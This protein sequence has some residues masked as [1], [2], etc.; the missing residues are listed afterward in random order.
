[1]ASQRIVSVP[2]QAQS[3]KH[4]EHDLKHQ[5]HALGMRLREWQN[6]RLHEFL[7]DAS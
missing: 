5:T 3:Q 2:Q 4:P 6:T 7:Q 1:V